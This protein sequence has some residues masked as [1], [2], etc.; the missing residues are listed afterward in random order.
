VL[1]HHTAPVSRVPA[2]TTLGHLRIRRGDPDASSP[3]QE[4]TALAGSIGELQRDGP[5]A[6]AHAEAKWLAGD[7][8]GV[9]GELKDVYELAQQ[10][11]DPWMKGELAA[12][13]WR[14]DGLKGMPEGI[15][16]PYAMEVSGNWHDAASAWCALGCP[17]EHA[18][19]LG[20]NGAEPEQREALTIFERLGAVPAAEALRRRMRTQGIRGFPRGARASTQEHPFNLTRREAQTLALMRNGLRNAAIAKRLC[21]SARTV[22]HHVSAVLAKLGVTSRAEAIEI[23]RQ[24]PE[25]AV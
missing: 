14:A 1:R 2:L 17:Y 20:W 6:V 24:Q 5:L 4:A 12:W 16:Q 21:I 11:H 13:L 18:L 9:I 10:R 23:A 3:L 15:A 8:G 7:L 25:L 19:V 22:D